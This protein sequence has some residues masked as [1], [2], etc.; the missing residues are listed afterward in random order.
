MKTLSQSLCLALLVACTP[1]HSPSETSKAEV[2]NAGPAFE[3]KLS[4]ALA[5]AQTQGKPVIAIFSAVWCGPCQ[6]MKKEVYPSTVVR[7]YH[8]KFVWAYIDADE[9]SNAPDAQKYGVQGIPHI[10]F[11]DKDGKSLDKQIG[12][13]SPEDFAKTLEG[14]LK[15]A[16]GSA[17]TAAAKS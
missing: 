13:S 3:H 11:L 5:K 2:S 10:E 9:E 6:M 1:N 12:A 15:K 7:P 8:D 16:G 4:D 14:V 17:V